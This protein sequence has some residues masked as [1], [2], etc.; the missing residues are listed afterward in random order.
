MNMLAI[1]AAG[2]QLRINKKVLA[3]F[4]VKIAVFIAELIQYFVDTQTA[5]CDP[6]KLFKR[7]CM[8]RKD[9][10]NTLK[11]LIKQNIV[12]KQNGFVKL[13]LKKLSTTL[14]GC[15]SV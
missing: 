10:N 2:D 1:L 8:S 3:S 11:K 6:E 15:E 13:N 5:E 12:L 9:F 7:S 4:G 14:Q